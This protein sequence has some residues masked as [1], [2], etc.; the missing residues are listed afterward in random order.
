MDW[1]EILTNC[2]YDGAAADAIA[3]ELTKLKVTMTNI[4]NLPRK[5]GLRIGGYSTYKVVSDI[6]RAA[7]YLTR[8]AQAVNPPPIEAGVSTVEQFYQ[9]IAKIVDISLVAELREMGVRPETATDITEEAFEKMG[10]KKSQIGKI[11]KIAGD[12]VG[13]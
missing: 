6:T 13:S 2:G 11:R 3:H 5:V 4:D 12:F 7:D 8:I 10:A 9:R 1:K